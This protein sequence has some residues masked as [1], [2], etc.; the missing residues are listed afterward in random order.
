MKYFIAQM[1]GRITAAMYRQQA[2][3]AAELD[4]L[5]AQIGLE[6]YRAQVTYHER[7][8]AKLRAGGE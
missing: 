3:E 2:L 8:I 7:L 4:L 5:K 6:H 1:F